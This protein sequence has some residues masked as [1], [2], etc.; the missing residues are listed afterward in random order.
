MGAGV[1]G[2]FLRRGQVRD[3]QAATRRALRSRGC[4]SGFCGVM[5]RLVSHSLTYRGWYSTPRRC[6]T[7]CATREAVQ[8]S[9]AKP[10]SEGDFFSQERTWRAWFLF[11]RGLGPG[12]GLAARAA[13]VPL[14]GYPA[15]DAAIGDA[16][17]AGDLGDR[18]ALIDGLD[19]APPTP[20]EL[21]C[22]SLRSHAARRQ[23]PE[24]SGKVSRR[25][26][27]PH[28]QTLTA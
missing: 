24:D 23:N 27:Q 17:D 6:L 14:G 9:V 13:L 11:R 18:R 1:P 7:R 16:E 4:R 3:R 15:A 2:V 12:W 25:R 10:N 28:S 21:L 19:G 8:S 26:D 5:P 20:F 22:A